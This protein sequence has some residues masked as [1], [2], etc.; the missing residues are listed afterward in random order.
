MLGL[1]IV[2]LSSDSNLFCWPS[3][4]GIPRS[5]AM[6]LAVE[7]RHALLFDDDATAAFVDSRD[8]L[9]PCA[10]DTSLLLDRYDVRHLLDRIPPRPPQRRHLRV[11][12]PGGGVS[13]SDLDH[14]RYLDLPP[15]GDGDDDG[16]GNGQ[17]RESSLRPGPLLFCIR[18]TIYSILFF[19]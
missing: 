2:F 8:A 6:D 12:D 3:L 14:E 5:S 16:D 9:V 7:G 19:I 18:S 1:S 17:G 4:A 13:L 15:P 10:A 11:E